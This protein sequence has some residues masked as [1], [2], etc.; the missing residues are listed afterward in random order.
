MKK[1]SYEFKDVTVDLATEKGLKYL[2]VK[3]S[4]V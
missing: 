4:D 2:G 1:E 3:R